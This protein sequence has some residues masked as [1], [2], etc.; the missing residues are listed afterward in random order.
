MKALI[1]FSNDGSRLRPVTC[2]KPRAMLPVL[3][4]PIID[5]TLY[6][7][8]RS[9]I[10]DV[11]IFSPS[12]ENSVKNH[13]KNSHIK[14]MAV[15]FVNGDS[16]A[17]FFKDDDVFIISDGIVTDI[18]IEKMQQ[19]LSESGKG[20]LLAVKKGSPA[21][22]YGVLDVDKDGKVRG[23]NHNTSPEAVQLHPCFTGIMLLRRGFCP[24]NT[25]GIFSLAAELLRQKNDCA[26]YSF[27]EYVC[28]IR[29]VES[30]LKC[31]RDFFSHKINLPF[32]CDE[33]EPGVWVEEDARVMG[34]A[35]IVPPVYIGH[36]A[37]IQKGARIESYTSVGEGAYIGTGAS[38]KRSI[39]MEQAYIGNACALRGA[40]I[41]ENSETADG[42]AVY[43]GGVLGK[44][45]VLGKRSTVRPAVK[46]W[47]E[48]SLPDDIFVS[49]NIVWENAPHTP[50]FSA[51]IFS[52]RINREITPEFACTLAS[53]C[54]KILGKKI[55]LSQSAGGESDMIKNALCAGIQAAGA[56]CYDFG[57]QP[58]P[59][60]RSGI[61]FYSLDGG[62]CVNT[63]RS[64]AGVCASIDIINSC[65]AN[66]NADE[67][68]K[69]EALITEGTARQY[70]A[71]ISQPEY[72]FEYK[73]YY[74]KQIINSTSREATGARVLIH[75]PSLW[76]KELLKSAARDM[77]AEFV[78]TEDG[79]KSRFS[80]KV[81]SENFD[82][83]A[84]I[85]RKCETLTPVTRD[86]RI[87]SEFEYSAL[88]A[89]I[90]MKSYKNA[91]IYAPDSSP[92]SIEEMAKKYNATVRRTLISAPVL[93]NELSHH[94]ES[95]FYKQFIYRF[96][97]LGALIMLLDFLSAE[98]TSLLSLAAEIPPAYVVT[99]TVSLCGRNAEDIIEKIDTENENAAIE[100]EGLRL[101]FDGGWALIIPSRA[102]SAFRI[103]SCA[104]TEEY[105]R[106][107]AGI[108]TDDI[109]KL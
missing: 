17:D 56:Q 74:L 48:K 2:T 51:G 20:A 93:M 89:L 71:V 8:K 68:A 54:E 72:L 81:Y 103:I 29:D 109:T 11:A 27:G 82:F 43:E 33:K 41:C 14:D 65:G 13:L 19:T 97:A 40:V 77:G 80:S 66:I 22:D 7:L 76:A 98:K 21:C 45:S 60:T 32:P 30:Y 1:T 106:E 88:V 47:P 25:G 3:G 69:L 42:A 28:D 34:G 101:T 83:G 9:K 73:L 10:N 50:L 61:R 38:V 46:I 67:S 15:S 90:I 87:L 64:D 95:L 12:T 62:I 107:I 5:H 100:D 36:G 94:S 85:D 57:E 49:S 102:Q 35:V 24:E 70:N 84:M 23:F 79:D 78:F 4:K 104:K 99:D 86:G 31:H 63:Y 52:G 92:D 44:C 53:C 108:C 55:A 26:A 59:I 16:L 91:V 37:N 75:C 6:L 105:A 96:D 18:D 58:L 39:I